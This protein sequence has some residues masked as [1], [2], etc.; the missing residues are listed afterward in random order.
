MKYRIRTATDTDVPAITEIYNQAIALGNATAHVTP[1]TESDRQAWLAEHAPD[2][3]PVYVAEDENTITGY[4]SISAYRPGRA[5]LRH[6]AE[7]SYYVHEDFRGQSVGSALVEHAIRECPEIGIRTL[8]AI[9]LDNNPGSVAL[10]EKFDFQ[11]WGH[12]PDVADFDGT[13][14]GHLYYGLRLSV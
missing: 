7:I 14:V 5:A 8:F 6:T 13:E 4:C 9:L 10:L 3:H 2:M 11:Q 1:V 12:M